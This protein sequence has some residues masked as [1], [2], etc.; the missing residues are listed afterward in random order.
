MSKLN[1]A[2][3]QGPPTP[4]SLAARPPPAAT[5]SGSG[6]PAP[7]AAGTSTIDL[8]RGFV[9]GH[10][11]SVFFLLAVALSWWAWLV[12]PGTLNPTGPA[13]AAFIVVALSGTE[14]LK[15]FA[16]QVADI[17]VSPRWLAAAILIPATVAVAAVTVN[18]LLGAPAPT[19]AQLGL[20]TGLPLEFLL[21]LV[22]VGFGEEIGWT[23]FGVPRALAGRTLLVAFVILAGMRALWHLPLMLSGEALWIEYLGMVAFQFLVLWIYRRSGGRWVTAAVFHAVNN[24]LTGSFLFQMVDGPDRVR[25]LVIQGTIYALFAFGALVVDR[26]RPPRPAGE[27]ATDRDEVAAR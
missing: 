16:R 10:Q 27:L 23:R 22:L 6:Q 9:A 1:P 7:N 8:V 12:D 21:L 4:T 5:A 25:L 24:V 19:G 13:I 2:K 3:P 15:R 17:R 20:W 11:L 26:L 18:T 14:Q